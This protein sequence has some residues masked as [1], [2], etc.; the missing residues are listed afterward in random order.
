M[1][2]SEHLEKHLGSI[3]GGWSE[4][5]AGSELD[6]QIVL[7]QNA[8]MKTACTLT[9]LGLS[10]ALLDQGDGSFIRQELLFACYEKFRFCDPQNLIAGVASQVLQS[11]HALHRGRVLGPLGPLFDSSPRLQALYCAVP[12]YFPR[13]FHTYAETSPVTI[14]VWLLPITTDEATY[15]ETRGWSTFE[16]ELS[17][18]DPDLLDLNR[19]SIF[20]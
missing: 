14:F 10:G 17:K 11:R 20:D 12:V 19:R 18:R 2:L 16:T 4:T 3:A 1:T 15:V 8:P 5:R 7:L 6:F 9:T 13:P